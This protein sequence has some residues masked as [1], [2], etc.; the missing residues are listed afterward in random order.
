MA[1][2]STEKAQRVTRKLSQTVQPTG[3]ERTFGTDEIIVSKTDPKGRITYANRVFSKV[4]GFDEGELLGAQH[5]IMR[6]PDM[7]R[8]I[9]KLL[10]DSIGAGREIFAYVKNLSKNGDHYWVLAHVTPS[11]GIDGT[12]L[13]YHSNR[14]VPER[15]VI[16]DTIV[17]LYRSLSAKEN[18]HHD[19][20]AGIASSWDMLHDLLKDKRASYDEFIFSL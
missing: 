9:F 6:H 5:S 16:D 10:W 11:I 4:S 19:R 20:K 18:E 2:K 17:P 13:G 12:V 3:R 15:R 7:P 8:C 1:K 14:R